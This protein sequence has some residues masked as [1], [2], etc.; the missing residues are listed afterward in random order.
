[1]TEETLS[2][3]LVRPAEPS[4]TVDEGDFAAQPEERLNAP[5][6]ERERRARKAA[7]VVAVIGA[8]LIHATVVVGL[9]TQLAFKPEDPPPEAIPIEIIPEPE[10]S[11]PPAPPDPPPP[12]Q[13]LDD[14][15]ATDAPQAHQKDETS[16]ETQQQA[17]SVPTP[18]EA[19]DPTPPPP[20]QAAAPPQTEE[21]DADIAAAPTP[22]ATPDG[23]AAT[24]APQT[25]A[26][27]APALPRMFAMPDFNTGPAFNMPASSP[28]ESVF[29]GKAK[30]TYLSGVFGQIAAHMPKPPSEGSHGTMNG[31]INFA[32]DGHG[33]LVRRTL[34]RSSGDSSYDQA[35]LQ[36]IG[37][38]SPY[39]VPPDHN[40]LSMEFHFSAN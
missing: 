39:D 6:T 32:V 31:Q 12:P 5:L 7:T 20:P 16:H 19:K 18:A 29:L 15:P 26:N 3:E 13:T 1:M 28:F 27:A 4:L 10:P 34:I 33:R 30:S 8:I 9:L 36:A 21:K 40:Q 23:S 2:I 35:V 11:P 38:A 24:P 22:A 37:A 25:E 17:A 14:T